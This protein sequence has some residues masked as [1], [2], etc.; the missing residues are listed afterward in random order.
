VEDLDGVLD[1]HDV[2]LAVGVDHVDHAR[3]GGGLA[4]AGGAGDQDE[5]ARLHC[6][7]GENGREAELVE[8]DGTDADATEDHAGRATGPEGVDA[9][10]PQ[11]RHRV[12]EVGLVGGGELLDQVVAQYLA[13]HVLGVRGGQ[14]GRLELAQPAVDADPRRRPH[15]D[16]QIGPAD[17]AEGA[18]EGDDGLELLRTTHEACF[19]PNRPY[20]ERSPER[21][22]SR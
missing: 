17:L 1:G 2:D 5:S 3:E 11:P 15:L 8:R 6:Q 19:G 10:P 14:R 13:H 18:Q 4:G 16:V 20:L 22:P 9:E 21:L 12:G 7:R